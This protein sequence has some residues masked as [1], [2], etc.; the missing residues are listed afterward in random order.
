MKQYVIII[1]AAAL[2]MLA[3]SA[4]I[5]AFTPAPFDPV[6][7]ERQ[8]IA[9][10]RMHI[11]AP[12]ETFAAGVLALMPAALAVISLV[13]LTAWG[14]VAVI[15]FRRERHPDSR[16]L[17]PVPVYRLNDMAPVALGAYHGTR[18]IEAAQQPVPH[19]VTYSPSEHYA[20]RLDYPG[21]SR[22]TA[23]PA[24]DESAPIAQ[25]PPVP[26]FAQLLDRGLVGRGNPLLMGY[27]SMGKPVEGSWLQLYSTAV[28]GL[29]GSG[30]SWTATF[31][32][33]Q[34]ALFGSRIVLLDP[35]A[36]DSES[37]AARLAPMHT[38]FVCEVASE[39]AQMRAAVELVTSELAR[40]KSGRHGEPWLFIADEF[41]AL[42]R[43]ELADPLAALVEGLSQEGRKL[44]MYAM[45]CGQVWSATRAGGT[46]LR[47]SL[48]SAYVH[49]LRPAQARMLTGMGT[50]ELPADLLQLPAGSAYL[51]DTAGDLRR[52]TIPQMCPADVA[53]VAQL[54]DS[55]APSVAPSTNRPLGFRP[56]RPE[57]AM[58]A[59]L[60]SHQDAG[61]WTPEEAQILAAL[62]AGKTPGEVAAE[63]AGTSGGRKYQE[64]SRRIAD[65]ISR[66]LG[67]GGQL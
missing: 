13:L 38:R 46:E 3:L 47:D 35:H 62:K 43:G 6:L 24:P 52:V 64:A 17:L 7:Y 42:Q 50:D 28:G 12:V 45:V 22:R 19:V 36:A 37:L 11:L 56:A 57:G 25:L 4:A 14:S 55:P 10:E 21:E 18:Q 44:G 63:L 32:A 48:A 27:D 30:K 66:A 51:L 5:T 65:L 58:E 8:Q 33:V 40:R 59:P 67:K 39:P 2:A 31:L 1:A 60:S 9:I 34:A 53:R 16:G 61:N 15:R 20:P 49:R 41:S 26:S 54:L 29:A 23:L